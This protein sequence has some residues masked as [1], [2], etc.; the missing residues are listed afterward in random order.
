[1]PRALRISGRGI[2]APF[3]RAALR[4]CLFDGFDGHEDFAGA[5]EPDLLPGDGL[6]RRGVVP[7]PARL[8]AERGVDPL[9]LFEITSSRFSGAIR[10]DGVHQ[11]TLAEQAVDQ[12]DRGREE[13]QV[14]PESPRLA[15][16]KGRPLIGDV[17]WDRCGSGHVD[18]GKYQ[19]SIASTSVFSARFSIWYYWGSAIDDGPCRGSSV[20]RAQH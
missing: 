7:Q 8:V 1:M 9:E 11:P 19:N 6:D 3:Y 10:T 14:R 20:G 4:G 18:D 16:R 13:R 17:R 12:E 5:D 15:P 2:E